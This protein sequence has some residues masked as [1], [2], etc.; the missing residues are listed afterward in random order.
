MKRRWPVLLGHHPTEMSLIRV[1]MHKMSPFPPHL[2]HVFLFFPQYGLTRSCVSTECSD[3]T[4]PEQGLSSSSSLGNHTSS[5]WSTRGAA[6]YRWRVT[7]SLRTLPSPARKQR[8]GVIFSSLKT[9]K[10]WVFQQLKRAC[11]THI[12]WWKTTVKFPLSQDASL[13]G[14]TSEA[15]L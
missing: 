1:I 11:K 7:S 4:H 12:V 8:G 14:C 15:N 13:A 9:L 5:C 10:L 3:P 2:S 6:G